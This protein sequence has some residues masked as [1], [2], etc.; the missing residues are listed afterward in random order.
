ME[1]RIDGKK[2]RTPTIPRSC[3][4]VW[5]QG[6]TFLV[7]N[8][9]TGI[10]YI[11]VSYALLKKKYVRQNLLLFNNNLIIVYILDYR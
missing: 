4:P 11:K 2:E 5:E 6:Y 8:P 9:E 1:A 7:S 10:L 3:D